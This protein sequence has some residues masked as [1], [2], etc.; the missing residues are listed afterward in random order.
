MM[1]LNAPA[2]YFTE[3]VAKDARCTE[4]MNRMMRFITTERVE[5][6]DDAALSRIALAS[7]WHEP[8]LKG[9]MRP[10]QEPPILFNTFRWHSDE[11]KKKR[12]EK[13]P[14]LALGEFPKGKL[15]GYIGFDW[16]GAAKQFGPGV[17][18]C[19]PAHE[20]HTIAGCPFRCDY[21]SHLGDV[22]VVMLNMEEFIAR[23]DG[24]LDKCPDQT[25][26]KWDNATDAPCF[27]PEYGGTKL[28]VDYFA[29]KP[30]KYLLLY[31]GKCADVDYLLD[32]DHRGKTIVA[33]SISAQTQS[34]RIEKGS[35]PTG[36]RIE[37]VRKC[38]QA[39]YIVR[40]RFSPIIPVRNWRDENR[41]MVRSFLS[42]VTPDVI[43]LCLF[44]WMDAYKVKRS[45]DVSLWD[46]R[47]VKAMDDAAVEMRGK[48]YG[49]LPH[50]ARA[51]MIR[52]FIDEIRA[53]NPRVPIALCLESFEM[54]QQFGP[55]LKMRPD[56]YLCN[57]GPQCTPGTEL[58]AEMQ[59]AYG[60]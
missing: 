39:G 48:A 25:L 44:G 55:E 30:G 37:A 33:F 29:R 14:A 20:M 41:A 7:G 35:A 50:D 45:L 1:R 8:R 23:M 40:V 11:E 18:V 28:F 19:Q 21:C 12:L 58:Y 60:N 27:E 53:V 26:F 3:D 10:Y 2:V 4:R 46:E 59:R 6:V 17:R 47:F 56:R 31:L 34:T 52:F 43:S 24:W 9:E 13:F 49:P 15:A 57:C 16:R 42:Q 54:W 51:E 38:Q 22:I 32:Y 36:A 5:K